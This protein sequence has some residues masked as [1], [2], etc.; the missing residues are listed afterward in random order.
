M[1]CSIP[2]IGGP[3]V[4]GSAVWTF[5]ATEVKSMIAPTFLTTSTGEHPLVGMDGNPNAGGKCKT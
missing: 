1:L 3:S 4:D 5:S 2:A